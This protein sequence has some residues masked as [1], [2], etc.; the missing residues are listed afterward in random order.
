MSA[1]IFQLQDCETVG[2]DLHVDVPAVEFN[3][4]H[5]VQVILVGPLAGMHPV[6]KEAD[7]DI[8]GTFSTK[9]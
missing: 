9:A 5:T 2:A 8:Q 4:Q 7:E 1:V 6:A 3:L